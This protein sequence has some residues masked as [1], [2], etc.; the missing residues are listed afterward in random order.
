MA[1]FGAVLMA[2]QL[3]WKASPTRLIMTHDSKPALCEFCPCDCDPDDITD[4]FDSEGPQWEHGSVGA[5]WGPEPGGSPRYN[6]FVD[7]G[8]LNISIFGAGTVAGVDFLRCGQRPALNGLVIEASAVITDNVFRT[9]V[10]LGPSI[11]QANFNASSQ[12]KLYIRNAAFSLI[13]T[14]QVVAEGDRIG[15]RITDTSSGAGT[16]KFDALHNGSIVHT[17]TGQSATIGNPFDHGVGAGIG[18]DGLYKY[19]DYEFKRN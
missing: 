5:I 18:N 12:I 15:L 11:V 17:L 2:A 10:I 6:V 13:E 9:R 19:D 7:A 8:E 4:A 1:R 14:S 16:Y 3:W